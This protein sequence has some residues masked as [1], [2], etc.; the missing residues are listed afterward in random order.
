MHTSFRKVV[1]V[2]TAYAAIVLI[3]VCLAVKAARLFV[4]AMAVW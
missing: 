3:A 1:I 2:C 4:E